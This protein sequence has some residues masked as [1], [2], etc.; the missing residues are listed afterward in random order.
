[1][2]VIIIHIFGQECVAKKGACQRL[3]GV[4]HE[5]MAGCPIPPKKLEKVRRFLIVFSIHI[6]LWPKITLFF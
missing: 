6:A 1:L 4:H 2:L 5:K 3:T